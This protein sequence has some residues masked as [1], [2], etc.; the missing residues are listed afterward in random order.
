MTIPNDIQVTTNTNTQS[1]MY[2]RTRQTFVSDLVILAGRALNSFSS[3]VDC[4]SN[5]L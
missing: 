4:R 2:V 1:E 5:A 3:P